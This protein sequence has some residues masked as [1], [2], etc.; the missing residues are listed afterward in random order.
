MRPTPQDV[1]VWIQQ[2]IPRLV[3]TFVQLDLSSEDRFVQSMR[4][5]LVLSRMKEQNFYEITEKTM[6]GAVLLDTAEGTTYHLP[7][8]EKAWARQLIGI[9]QGFIIGSL[10]IKLEDMK[11][12]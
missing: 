3:R 11:H 6:Y 1:H 8:L 10:Y 5:S 7:T 4:E 12:T 9:V 2:E